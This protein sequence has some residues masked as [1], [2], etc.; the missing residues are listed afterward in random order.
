MHGFEG[1]ITLSLGQKLM[2]LWSGMFGLGFR[3][4]GLG[5]CWGVDFGWILGEVRV[6]KFGGQKW[7]FWI[8]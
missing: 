2:W 7:N 4:G 3:G 5:W 1:K 8:R 6:G